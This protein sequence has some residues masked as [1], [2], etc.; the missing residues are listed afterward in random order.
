[1]SALVYFFSKSLYQQYHIPL[2]IIKSAQGGSLAEAWLSEASIRKF[3]KEAALLSKLQSTGYLDSLKRSDSLNAANWFTNVWMA[4]A[5]NKSTPWLSAEIKDNDWEDISVPGRWKDLGKKDFH[6]VAWYRKHFK[7]SD[8]MASH[9]T[10]LWLGNWVDR[11]SVFINGKFV[12]TTGYQYPPRKYSIPVGILK[13]GENSIAVRVI[14]YT[15]SGGSYEDKSYQ[16]FNSTDTIQL[17]GTWKFR[18]GAELEEMPATTALYRLPTGL[19]NG[20][21]HPLLPYTMKGLIWYQGESNADEFPENYD[22]L[23]PELI[24]SWRRQWNN[25]FPF[26]YVQLANY[27]KSSAEPQESNW[28]RIRESQRLALKLPKTGMAVAMDVGEWNDIHPMNKKAVGERLSLLAQNIVYNRS[29]IVASGPLYEGNKISGNQVIIRFKNLGG[30]LKSRNGA[31]AGFA[32]AG[33]DKRFVW[34]KAVIKNNRVIV[35]SPEIIH[36]LYVRYGWADNP[37]KANLVNAEGLPADAFTTE[38]DQ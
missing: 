15:G 21:I 28:A 7:V 29:G 38:Y 11:D 26:L 8:E 13:P 3:P 24:S 20:M 18:I 27:M 14:N 22:Y 1:M 9:P 23:F 35:E 6:G 5:G 34:A 31:L 37:D 19:Y 16:L 17:S 12:G 25:E 30:G 32:I 10:M 4:D 2:G 36:P 33:K